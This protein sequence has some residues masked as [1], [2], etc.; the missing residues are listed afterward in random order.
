MVRDGGSVNIVEGLSMNMQWQQYKELELVPDSAPE[1]KSVTPL[2]FAI[3][4]IAYLW[5]SLLNA[6]AR[7][8]LY[9]QRTEYFERCWS[10]DYTEPYTTRQAD[11]FKKLLTLMD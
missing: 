2:Q 5:R 11:Q 10:A 1:P 8:H 9:E 4:P 3:L 6:L 7:E